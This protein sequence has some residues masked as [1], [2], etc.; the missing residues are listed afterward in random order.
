M[1][2]STEYALSSMDTMILY[3]VYN[4][5]KTQWQYILTAPN[6]S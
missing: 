2:I 4:I 1:C 6:E 5:A 3:D